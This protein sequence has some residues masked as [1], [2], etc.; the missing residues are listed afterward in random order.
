V[1]NNNYQTEWLDRWSESN[2]N[3]NYPRVTTNDTNNNTRPSDFYVEDASYVRLRN[4]QLGYNLPTSILQK[5]KMSAL[6]I[7]VSGD[8]LLTV[9][10]YS[11]FDPEVGTA[12]NSN[13]GTFNIL[14]TGIDKGFY[15]QMKT[16]AAGINVSL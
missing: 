4:L 11:G 3:G 2:P 1:P 7:Y 12:F 6:R 5:L 16:F 14:D 10:G 15:P 8:N 13:N 9:T